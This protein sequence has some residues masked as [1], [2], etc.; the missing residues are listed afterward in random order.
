MPRKFTWAVDQLL[1]P[2]NSSEDSNSQFLSTYLEQSS[3]SQ[4][5]EGINKAG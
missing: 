3:S 1:E 2:W 5:I 4:T